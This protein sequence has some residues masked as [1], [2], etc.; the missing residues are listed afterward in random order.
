MLNE[1]IEYFSM[2]SIDMK[3]NKELF[4]SLSPHNPECMRWVEDKAMKVGHCSYMRTQQAFRSTDENQFCPHY[5]KTGQ[6]PRSRRPTKACFAI[7]HRKGD[8]AAIA[9]DAQEGRFRLF[10]AHILQKQQALCLSHYT[11]NV[12]LF[13]IDLSQILLHL[14]LDGP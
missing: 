13:T 1:V 10:I 14:E 6:T 8:E 11:V 4:L 5:G 12:L 2:F 3:V 9:E 7:T